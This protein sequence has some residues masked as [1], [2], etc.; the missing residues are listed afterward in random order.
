M[1]E[2][3][4]QQKTN[5]KEQMIKYYFDL[6]VYAKKESHIKYIN[7]MIGYHSG[8]MPLP[9]KEVTSAIEYK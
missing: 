2:N 4:K 6:L 5:S 9:E 8:V 3:E 7:E 1:T